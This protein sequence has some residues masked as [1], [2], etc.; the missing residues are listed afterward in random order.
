M[1]KDPLSDST[2]LNLVIEIFT[3]NNYVLGAFILNNEEL[4]I[5]AKHRYYVK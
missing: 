1:Y 4:E 3:S 2:S 5:Q